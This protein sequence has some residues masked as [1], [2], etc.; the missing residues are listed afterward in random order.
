M[1][2]EWLSPI[3]LTAANLYSV[4]EAKG[5]YIINGS[6]LFYIGHTTNLKKRLL[7]HS[8]KTWD[9]HMVSCQYCFLPDT[10]L[11]HQLKELESDLIGAYY[12]QTRKIPRFQFV[13]SF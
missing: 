13:N 10:T 12:H 6:D 9:D 3:G 1:G 8:R 4:P 7:D 2:L 11:P 5:L